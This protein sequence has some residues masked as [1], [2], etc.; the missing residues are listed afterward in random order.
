MERWGFSNKLALFSIIFGA[1]LTAFFALLTKESRETLVLLI[2]SSLLLYIVILCLLV[3]ILYLV[4]K[5]EKLKNNY[6]LIES[7]LGI[8]LDK[9][10]R[11]LFVS[12]KKPKNKCHINK[13]TLNMNIIDGQLS[14]HDVEYTWEFEG[15]NDKKEVLNYLYLAIGGDNSISDYNDIKLEVF[16]LKSDSNTPYKPRFKQSSITPTSAILEI[17]FIDNNIT[18][19]KEFHIKV[20]YTWP[21]NYNHHMDYFF[22]D[23]VNFATRVKSV[24][25]KINFENNLISQSEL[26]FLK[27]DSS[28]KYDINERYIKLPTQNG[29][30]S[31]IEYKI[32]NIDDDGIY[33]VQTKK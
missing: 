3:Y 23:I 12:D 15:Y 22:V 16:D 2:N 8:P 6:P 13:F 4:R 14:R 18:S 20:K 32:D 25:I 29:N 17:P 31:C 11:Y 19:G 21:L 26:V 28:G 33:L 24:D 27:S 1:V 5:N 30:K 10:V 7:L 9:V